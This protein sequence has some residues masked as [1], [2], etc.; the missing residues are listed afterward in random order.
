VRVL[1]KTVR[2]RDSLLL[3]SGL[4]FMAYEVFL[5]RGPERWGLMALYAG[6]MGLPFFMR[7]D[8]QSRRP[9]DSHVERD[10]ES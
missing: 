5:Y 6:M 8:E 4:G 3:F 10:A 1:K 9:S 2:Y 7:G